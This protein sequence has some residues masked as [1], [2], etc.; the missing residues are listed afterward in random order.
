MK[1]YF[2]ANRRNWNDRATIHAGSEMYAIH[3][4]TDDPEAIGDTVSF[5]RPYLGDLGGISAVHL[6]C[7][8]GTDTISLAR[9]G[10][11]VT[12]LD[13]SEVSIAEAEKLFA[14]TGTPGRFVIANV[15]DAAEALG[16]TYD[17]VYTGVGAINWLPDIR[18]WADVVA[19]LLKPGGRLYIRD[20]HPMAATLDDERTDDSLVVKYP[21]FE[22]EDPMVW[23]EQVTYT[24]GDTA[25]MTNTR[26]YAWAHGLGETVMAVIDAG[27]VLDGLY[28][29]RSL[30]WRMLPHMVEEGRDFMLPEHQRDLAPMMFSLLASK[31]E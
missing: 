3:R 6:Q 17:L 8:I 26:H 12:G 11:N 30:P 24:D 5:D 18:L 23:D 28:E 22:T 16:E 10:A 21:Y 9:L 2:E 4:F 31:P 29:H 13:Q 25:S 27:L 14:A 7:H 15:Y 19:S 1:E 20:G